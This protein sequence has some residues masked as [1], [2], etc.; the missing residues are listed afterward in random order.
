[1][2]PEIFLA[3]STSVV[4]DDDACMRMCGGVCVQRALR[5]ARRDAGAHTLEQHTHTH[6]HCS[7]CA[8][9]VCVSERAT[10]AERRHISQN[11]DACARPPITRSRACAIR[12]LAGGGQRAD[13]GG[14]GSSSIPAARATTATTRRDEDVWSVWFGAALH[15]K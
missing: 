10:Q 14:G 1:M 8:R 11:N 9:H 3:C 7:A 5:L 4:V 2:T 15:M 12:G 6:T 13:N